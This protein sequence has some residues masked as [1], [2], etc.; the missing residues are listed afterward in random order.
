[1]KKSSN[2]MIRLRLEQALG[3]RML[4]LALLLLGLLVTICFIQTCLMFWGHERGAVPSAATMWIGNDMRSNA[5]LMT[6][7]VNYLLFPLTSAIFADCLHD[8]RTRH[9]TY[10]LAPRSSL[11]RYVLSGALAAFVLAFGVTLAL[12]VISQLLAFFAFP[13][14]ADQDAY[15]VMTDIAATDAQQFVSLESVPFSHLLFSNRYLYNLLY[16]LNLA[17]WA[18]AMSL[19]SYALSLYVRGGRL[20]LLGLPTMV[21]LAFSAVMPRGY[22]FSGYLLPPFSSIGAPD[23]AILAAPLV[24]GLGAFASILVACARRNDVVI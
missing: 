9:A 16:C 20:V 14:T 2:R 4:P 19:V 10:L 12:F 8:E 1:M 7:I 21:F 5:P 24:V 15:F 18:G 13:P 17:L 23:A 22:S 11:R 6:F 3:S